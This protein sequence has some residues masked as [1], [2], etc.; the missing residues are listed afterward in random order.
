M[1][2]GADDP[3]TGGSLIITRQCEMGNNNKRR[4]EESGQ[5]VD[6]VV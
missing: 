5:A 1:I 4:G 2:M 6:V 3:D